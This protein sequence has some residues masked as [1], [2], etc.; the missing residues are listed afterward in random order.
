VADDC[1]KDS[2]LLAFFFVISLLHPFHLLWSVL[3]RCFDTHQANHGIPGIHT[4]TCEMM[5]L[6]GEKL[7]MLSWVHTHPNI[8]RQQTALQL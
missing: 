7:A 5:Q 3:E 2:I 1:S 6:A 8:P 4:L